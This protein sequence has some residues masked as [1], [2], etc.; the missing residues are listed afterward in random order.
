MSVETFFDDLNAMTSEFGKPTAERRMSKW[1]PAP[2]VVDIY[3]AETLL[4]GVKPRCAVMCGDNNK[5]ICELPEYRWHEDEKADA[6]NAQ[7]IAAAPELY[8]SL[9]EV[10]EAFE[11][12]IDCG[13]KIDGDDELIERAEAALAKARGEA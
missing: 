13:G 1:T 10:L 12:C 4:H 5:V 9:E 8:A 7:L 11:S 6:A 3:T 2:W